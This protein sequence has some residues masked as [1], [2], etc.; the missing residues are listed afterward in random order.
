MPRRVYGKALYPT[1]GRGLGQARYAGDITRTDIEA[2]LAYISFQPG[3]APTP[4]PTPEPPPSEIPVWIYPDAQT[5]VALAV[6]EALRTYQ[7]QIVGKSM[8]SAAWDAIV[9][10]AQQRAMNLYMEQSPTP[11]LEGPALGSNGY[12][13]ED[14]IGAA[15]NYILYSPNWEPYV[16]FASRT[17]QYDQWDLFLAYAL[18]YAQENYVH[19]MTY[20]QGAVI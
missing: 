10:S 14:C 8:T 15:V 16:D 1:F 5:C 3:P 17:I 19:G 9:T 18:Y 2:Y 11:A 13:K 20:Y 12:T 7:S 6:D 4:I